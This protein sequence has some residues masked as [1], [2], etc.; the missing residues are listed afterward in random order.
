VCNLSETSDIFSCQVPYFSVTNFVSDLRKFDEVID[1]RTESE[2]AEDRIFNSI[3]LPVLD[4]QQRVEIG[5]LYKKEKSIARKLGAALIN[6]NTSEHIINH[7][8]TKDLSYKPLI[9]CWR[10]GH[11]S[12]SLAIILKEIGFEPSILSGGYKEYRKL[13]RNTLHIKAGIDN[14]IKFDD[15]KIVL[16]SGST[17]SGKSLLLET[18]EKRGEQVLHLEQ[19]AKHKGS[20]LGDY[21]N[22]SQPTQKL[23]ETEAFE[24]LEFQFEPNKVIWVE[25]ESSKIGKIL[26]PK[27]IWSKMLESPRIHINVEM[28][29]RIRFI[30]KDYDYMCSDENKPLLIEILQRLKKHIGNEKVQTWCHYVHLS[31]YD[32]LVEDLIEDYYD[33]TYKKPRGNALRT[34]DVPQGLILDPD[35][36]VTSYIIDEIIKFGNSHIN[37][38]NLLE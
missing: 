5:T 3:N 34:F 28:Q 23:F 11:R 30:L 35:K 13:V 19:L 20:V 26:L 1:V 8:M 38:F 16:I 27:R 29:D 10:G 4:N 22:E 25:N 36:M 7:F 31:H 6:K 12:K 33:K 17:G 32:K 2:F 18:L 21:P 24:K 9:Y 37:S 15:C 14:K